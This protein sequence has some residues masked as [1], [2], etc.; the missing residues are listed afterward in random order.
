MNKQA[1]IPPSILECISKVL[2][3]TH[4]G[5]TNPEIVDNLQLRSIDDPYKDVAI[6]KWRRLYY[7][8]VNYQNTK[9]C[10][11]NIYLFIRDYFSPNRFVNDLAKF[12]DQRESV[13]LQL[14]FCGFEITNRGTISKVKNA[15]TIIEAQSR[16]ESF[17]Q[18]LHNQN[19]HAAIIQYAKAE[20][21]TNDYFHAVLE[22]VKGL[23]QR[24]RNYTGSNLDGSKLI[25]AAFYNDPA[26]LINQ[27]ISQ[28]D[29]DEHRGFSDV[30]QGLNALVR[31]PQSHT[32]RIN[33]N[34]TEQDAID[35]FAL[36]SYCHRKLDNCNVI[37]RFDS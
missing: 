29:K 24:I 33:A 37:K 25:Q 16:A 27:F 36:I 11:N 8:F 9:G 26:I 13:N 34:F 15:T 7:A 5:Y 21:L 10:S 6:T 17:K 12:N 3:D 14:R 32:P 2:G 23:Y 19:A 4:E 35:I 22:A 1:L 28:S 31:N 20:L 18:K 30:L